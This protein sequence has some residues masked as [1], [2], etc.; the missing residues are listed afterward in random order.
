MVDLF[1]TFT[2]FVLQSFVL[3]IVS[4]NLNGQNCVAPFNFKFDNRTTTSVDISWSDNN[5]S[6][7][8]W[9]IEIVI[10]GKPRTNVPTHTSTQKY[11]H[12][13]GLTPSTA[14]ELYIRTVCSEGKYS[15]WNVAIPFVTVVE[16]PSACALN[17][18]LKDNGTETLL[19]DV[20]QN[21]ILGKNVFLTS[22]ELMIQHSW[23]ADLN[24]TLI[25]PQGQSLVLSAHN[26]IGQNNF[27]NITDTKCD[28]VT[29]F[30][31]QACQYLRESKP[32]YIGTFKPDGE[33]NNWKP[34]TLSKGFW[35][36]VFFDRALKDAGI[37][38]YVNLNFNTEL[39]LIP[40]AFT[41]GQTDINSVTLHWEP[42]GLCHT[43][44]LSVYRDSLISKHFVECSQGAFSIMGLDPNTEYEF[45][46]ISQC[47]S[48]ISPISCRLKATTSC[49]PISM[50]SS[51]DNLPKCNEGCAVMCPINDIIW[52]NVS[53]DSGQDWLVWQGKTDT[54]NTGP[55]SDINQNGKYIYIE[56]NPQL[57]GNQNQVILQSTCMDIIS[58]TSGCDMSFYYNMSGT[59]IK[60][61][62]L[63]ISLD[64]ERTWTELM[65]IN[66]NQG[67]GWK[68][69]TLSLAPY[70]QKSGIFRFKAISGAGV[71]ADI[72]L[73]QI[74]FYHSKVQQF[75]NIYYLDH[76]QDGYGS[77]TQKLEICS[78]FAPQGFAALGGDCDDDNKNIHPGA[79]E[80]PCNVIDENC[81]GNM[82]DS[83]LV[84]PLIISSTVVQPSCN[85][86]A[87]G[88]ITLQVS[89]GTSPYQIH[90]NNQMSGSNIENLKQG[91][92]Y[93]DI[94]DQGGC[95]VR[96]PFF[97]LTATSHLNVI[98]AGMKNPTCTGKSD[99]ALQIAH[100]EEMPPYTY[101]W[102]NGATTKNLTDVAE[103]IY[104]VTISDNNHCYIALNDIAL[105]SKPSLVVG[106][107]TINHP[108]CPGQ[109]TGHIQILA[110]NGKT[111]Y[112]YNW[113]NG[114]TTDM[115]TNLSADHYTVTVTDD[116]GCINVVKAK[117][118]EPEAINI[119]VVSTEDVRCH[120]E[121]NGIIKTEISGGTTPYTFLWNKLTERTDDIFNLEAG[122]YILT[123]T[124]ANGCKMK[125][126]PIHIV[127]PE[128]FSMLDSI[129]DATCIAGTNGYISV[130]GIGGNG[131]YHYLW[132]HS[133]ESV[134][135]FDNLK[136]GNYSVT[137][138][139]KLGCK[140]S[141]PNIS[142]GYENKQVYVDIIL[143]Q[144]NR[145]YLDKQAQIIANVT[146][147]KLPLDYNWSHG[148]QYFKNADQDTLT[149]LGA[150]NY[151]L[152]ITDADGCTGH[153]LPII[154]EEKPPFFYKVENV[155]HNTCPRDSNGA[156]QIKVTGGVPP[157][158][159]NWEGGLYAGDFI[160]SLANGQYAAQIKDANE[161][162]LQVVAIPIVS[163]SN[164]TVQQ[165]IYHDVD[166]KGIGKICVHPEGG[167]SPYEFQWSTGSTE[168]C[169]DKLMSGKYQLTITDH[170][171]CEY[172]ENFIVENTS[173]IAYNGTP[174]LNIYPNP[175]HDHLMIKG[176]LT[177][178]DVTIYNID[179]HHIKEM[180]KINKTESSIDL[181]ELP[182]GLYIL[183]VTTNTNTFTKKILKM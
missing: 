43:V 65:K 164:V 125:T 108:A 81:N 21:G 17:I 71:L 114:H 19:L 181:S 92:Y 174:S 117:I 31:P 99:G 11:I 143:L 149:H 137:A 93:A 61:L 144:E 36:L 89:G 158:G 54:E 146:E 156:I 163:S 94:S 62:A 69:V 131:D 162:A 165:E 87:D 34:D 79:L 55:N 77:D 67:E 12:L 103:G 42:N 68:R 49:E 139:D 100:N 74:E 154:L 124:D 64:N 39:C 82:D 9:E 141:I 63:E 86:S 167:V 80:I 115:I 96:T 169:I 122:E 175:C 37:L 35:K 29:T 142:L 25:S 59:D 171:D 177:I 132:S 121:N 161:C 112:H 56:N 107:K 170:T 91:V 76:D 70:H 182:K 157:I 50:A 172:Y 116:N 2:Y 41:I 153:S 66:G 8:S 166:H 6:P 151:T 16:V 138:Y 130:K 135:S 30:S 18:P 88:Q 160:T 179:K 140:A 90:W 102:S 98:L 155:V 134:S 4:L 14:Y 40:E 178:N 13:N 32:P 127:Q 20:P 147:A 45:S 46:I 150:G 73:D 7:E 111:P 123:V 52:H 72:A 129:H 109:S 75:S 173:S 3:S 78:S 10:K 5:T 101:K 85:G 120:G 53:E 83:P 48:S 105:T 183:E 159:I 26:G 47:S 57:C 97:Q 1:K 119:K 126:D 44:Q 33:L 24:I 23:P 95:K 22:V 38:K 113:S 148:V 176:S 28:Q 106:I 60:S 104:S 84:N 118:I 136:A 145:C 133:D 128:P 110:I 180:T 152:S 27:G 15:N 58:N 51:F 168:T